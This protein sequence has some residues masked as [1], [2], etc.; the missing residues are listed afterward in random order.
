MPNP[1]GYAA[2][3]WP[4]ERFDEALQTISSLNFRGVQM[5][6]WV[7]EA[8]GGAK[9]QVLKDRLAELRLQPVTLSCSDLDLNPDDPRDEIVQLRSYAAFFQRL[10]GLYLQITDGGSPNR[11]YSASEIGRLGQRMNL[12]GGIA[13]DSGLTLGY[14]PHFGTIG[15]TREGLD[16]VLQATDARTVKLIADVGHLA[17]G[18]ADPAEVVRAYHERLI[19]LHFKDVRRDI[20]ELSRQN[21]NLVRKKEYRFC[22][23][24]MGA[25]DFPA[26]IQAFRDTQFKGWVIVEL[27]GNKPR[28][29][30][31]AESARTNKQ[32]ALR[33]GLQV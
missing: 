8:Y 30:G 11:K 13:K 24:G 20:F 22:E 28:P 1:V 10:G 19:F 14:H 18:G 33:L 17:L 2:I 21:R 9:T 25:V 6:G 27:D 12:L 3:A 26:V 23:I 29:G 16:R 15:E 31:P 5:L 7:R 32:A 4:E